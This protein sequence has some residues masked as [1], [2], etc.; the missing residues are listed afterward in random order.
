M[1]S[2]KIVS[3]G[4]GTNSTAILVGLYE[5]GE[6]PDAIT[7]ADTGGEKPHTYSHLEEVNAWC[8]RVG[9]PLVTVVKGSQPQQLKDGGL[10]EECIRLG[11]L[12]S[13]A[14]GFSS[15]SQKW[16]IEP[17]RKFDK[18][19][20]E[21][22]GIDLKQITRLIGFDADEHSRV[23]RALS[24]ADRTPTQ[25]AFPLYEWGWGREECVEAIKRAGLK[26]PGKSAC[27]YCP[28]TK[29]GEILELRTTYPL[30]FQKAVEM[31][32]V[33]LAG[34]GKAPALRGKGLGRSFNWG[35]F[36]QQADIEMAKEANFKERQI[37][38]FSDAGA[39]EMDCGCY[40]GD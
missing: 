31:E 8:E 13:K 28:S 22:H 6:R 15:C 36:A 17:Q 35:E 29:K 18:D 5:R 2:F 32:R 20:A 24:Y 25:Q 39:V 14:Y 16:K 34:E 3:Y 37:D 1:S 10:Y 21:K 7:F 19:F 9:F 11:V 12:P 23:E 27:F 33:A 30:L 40:D 26:Q 4:A 38:L